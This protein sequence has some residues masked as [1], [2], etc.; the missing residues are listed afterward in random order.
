MSPALLPSLARHFH[1]TQ[2][3][4]REGRLW[5]LDAHC[6][7]TG[8]TPGWSSTLYQEEQVAQWFSA[9]PPAA[10]KEGTRDSDPHLQGRTSDLLLL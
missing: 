5:L 9:S 7:N 8:F 10:L 3:A 2:A 1:A 6:P 4:F